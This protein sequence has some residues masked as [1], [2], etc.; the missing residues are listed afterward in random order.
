M[1]QQLARFAN[2]SYC[3]MRTPHSF[4]T[5]AGIWF[6]LL[7][8]SSNMQGFRVS[9]LDR[10][11][12][13]LLYREIFVRQHYY[14]R[15]DT[16]SPLIFDCGANIGM[17]TL[18]F[19]WLYPN[20]RVHAFE[21]DPTTFRVLQGNI[22][23]NQLSDVTAHNCALWDENC[24]IPFF[25]HPSVQGSLRM[26]ADASRLAGVATEIS[27]PGERLSDFIHGPIDLLK[28]DTE[29]AEHRILC[30][31][32]SKSK[33]SLIRS[34]IIEYHHKHPAKLGGFL[35]MLESSGFAYRLAATPQPEQDI[36]IIA[37]RE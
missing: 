19:K 18:F 21:P 37:S 26:S 9:Y 15:S 12:Y 28:L 1:I 25:V 24:S 10:A 4:S 3:L 11:S 5:K 33:I 14:F 27:V 16:D 29:G 17:A 6:N 35:S 36:M 34:M 22:A 7:R 30:D 2:D 32:V 23:T 31:L 20:A 8:P 13:I